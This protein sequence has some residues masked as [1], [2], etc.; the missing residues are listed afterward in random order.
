M[1]TDPS[2]FRWNDIEITWDNTNID[3]Y[4]IIN[5]PQD[6]EYYNPLK[7]IVFQMEPWVYDKNRNWGVKVWGEWANPDK[8]RFLSVRGRKTD[9]HNNVFWHIELNLNQLLTMKFEKTK[10]NKISTICSSNYH[11][12]GHILRIEFLKF[13]ENKIN[14]DDNLCV[15]IY[16]RDNNHNFKNYK[17]PLTAYIDKSLGIVPYKYYFM[18]EN[19]FE[20]DFITE[21]IWEPI[22]CETLCFY[23]GCPNIS[24]YLDPLSYVLLDANNFEKS[25]SIIKTAIEEDWWSQRIDIIRKEKDKILN[26][27]SFF[28]IVDK[29]IKTDN[30]S[31]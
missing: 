9:T 15:D 2:N 27:M 10:E 12:E 7:T 5:Y 20:K 26:Q 19:N 23:Y 29:I 31:I 14:K 16:N 18:M 3:Y 30:T 8:S 28:P 25:Y 22:L 21:K 1:C 13:L 17:G 11:D 24:D 4:V 6:N